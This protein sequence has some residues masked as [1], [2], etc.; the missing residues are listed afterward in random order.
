MRL[1]R[2]FR[3]WMFKHSADNVTEFV[4]VIKDKELAHVRVEKTND[5]NVTIHSLYID[6]KLIKQKVYE[7]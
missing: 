7:R 2:F 1:M 6:N 5:K 4:I 3:R